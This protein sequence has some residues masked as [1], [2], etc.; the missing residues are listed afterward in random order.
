[1]KN[2]ITF[3]LMIITGLSFCQVQSPFNPMPNSNDIDVSLFGLASF[4][5]G[6]TINANSDVTYKIYL[7]INTSPTTVYTNTSLSSFDY[8]FGI[9]TVEFNYNSLLEN[10]DYYWKVEVIDTSNN[11]LSTSPTWQFTTI[12][13]SG[14]GI[15]NG[16]AILE[17]QAEVDNFNFTEITGQLTVSES[18]SGAITNL[19]GLTS[20]TTVGDG[21]SIDNNSNLTSLNGLNNLSSITGSFDTL[22]EG[23]GLK[24]SNNDG[25]TS[26]TALGNLTSLNGNLTI[27]SNNLL[28]G[29]QGLEGLTVING[30]LSIGNNDQLTSLVGL[31]NITT[32]NGL[33]LFGGGM[34]IG[35][36]DSLTS[37]NGLDS[38]VIINGGITIQSQNLIN[39]LTGLET[40][41][42]IT[43]G[44]LIRLNDS[45]LSFN[46]LD[47]LSVL[48]GD[49]EIILNNS[50]LTIA[51]PNLQV[52]GGLL[53]IVNNNAMTSLSGLETIT[54]VNGGLVI[55]SNPN[56]LTLGGLDNL[57]SIGA[58]LLIDN[59]VDAAGNPLPGNVSLSSISALGSLASIGEKAT[60]GQLIITGCSSLTSL[61]GLA[62]LNTLKQEYYFQPNNKLQ[63]GTNLTTA[64]SPTITNLYNPL[65]TDFCALQRVI[66]LG[67]FTTDSDIIIANNGNNPS[68]SDIQN[69]NCSLPAA[70]Q[71]VFKWRT[72]V[73]NTTSITETI[74]GITATFNGN[75]PILRDVR[76]STSAYAGEGFDYVVGASTNSSVTFSFSE[77][78]DVLS[79]MTDNDGTLR[80]H[81]FTPTGGS[82]NIVN[83]SRIISGKVNLNWSNITSFTVSTDNSYFA[84]DDLRVKRSS[85]LSNNE[86]KRIDIRIYPNPTTDFIKIETNGFVRRAELFNLQGQKVNTSFSNNKVDVQNIASGVYFLK[87]QTNKGEVTKKVVKK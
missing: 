47:N 33:G 85:T 6:A 73:N 61:D 76:L 2:I 44:A 41:T 63:I 64:N 58:F 30:N 60:K 35:G 39:S 82:N 43:G 53:R 32:V 52:I 67:E 8:V 87:L 10:T 72:A 17:T 12:N 40:L 86:F 28:A 48:S 69:L 9:D 50:L 14:T 74:D 22:G 25:L 70:T 51:L 23:I 83:T 54:S 66:N 65:L 57:I 79:I 18:S 1:M 31:N 36:N 34:G 21:I 20:L 55:R 45:L 11:V 29:L 49:L 24:I 75:N 27:S 59:L 68:I 13:L 5:A 56:L 84:F 3:L 81:I 71:T 7:D 16:D 4:T 42:T 15:F 62:N 37:L 38:L 78:V 19:T 46:G 26:V 77:P 80:N